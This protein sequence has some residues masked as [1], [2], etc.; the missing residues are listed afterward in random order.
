MDSEKSISHHTAYNGLPYDIFFII[1]GFIV[2]L[3][4]AIGFCLLKKWIFII[5]TV[6]GPLILIATY[7]KIVSR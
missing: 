3:F 5:S 4:G 1:V 2:T 7:N 6:F